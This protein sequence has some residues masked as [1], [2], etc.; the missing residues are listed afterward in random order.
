MDGYSSKRVNVG[1]LSRKGPGVVLR[2]NMKHRDQSNQY[3]NRFGCTGRI[4]S[5]SGTQVGCSNKSS[6]KRPFRSS[7]GKEVVGSSSRS[8]SAIRNLRKSYPE[9]FG[10]QSSK[11]ELDSSANDSIHDELEELEFIS[12]PGLFHTGHH[13]KSESS[14]PADAMLM[15]MGSCSMNSNN[16]SRRNS[17]QRYEVD[18]EDTHASLQPTSLCQTSTG[19][20]SRFNSRNLACDSVSEADR[21]LLE[22]NLVRRMNVTKK[23]SYDGENSSSSRGKKVSGTSR[24]QKCIYRHGISISDQRPGRNVFHRQNIL[25][26]HGT[27]SLTSVCSGARHSYQAISDNLS[28]QDP[29]ATISWTPQTNVS[30]SSNASTSLQL[31]SESHS[32]HRTTYPEPEGYS[33][34]LRDIGQATPAEVGI[35]SPSTN[36]N[37]YRCHNVDGIAEVLLALERIEQ[38]EELTYEQALLLETTML[39]NSLNIYDQHRDMRLDIDNMT[40]EQ[41]LD[42]EERMGTVSTALSEEALTECLNRSIY[43]SKPKGGTATGSVEDLSDV[44]CCICQEEY[45]TGDEVG[46]LQCAHKYHVVCIQQWLRLKNWCPICKSSAAASHPFK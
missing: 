22:P 17:I 20:S 2:D 15:E 28:L 9:P 29:L 42:L 37:S 44:K 13:A 39:L 43:Q 6:S 4:C 31:S 32:R 34:S 23:M 24:G 10:K 16:K 38:E 26:S 25:S 36:A 33:Q 12:P 21:S 19:G 7:S 46:K 30:S 8:S 18:N 1:I 41:L 14:V 45:V 3:G 35:S 27:Q 11:L 5:S 40:Y